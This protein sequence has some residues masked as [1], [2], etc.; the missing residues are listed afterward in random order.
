[1]Q[2]PAADTPVPLWKLQSGGTCMAYMGGNSS[3]KMEQEAGRMW[4]LHYGAHPVI[5]I[6]MC[7]TLLMQKMSFALPETWVRS[8]YELQTCVFYVWLFVFVCAMCSLCL[9]WVIIPFNVVWSLSEGNFRPDL[10][11]K[12]CWLPAK[13]FL[14]NLLSFEA[15][16]VLPPHTAH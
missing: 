12:I 3:Q 6:D 11:Q 8:E 5:D 10:K 1:M 16:R 7:N 2:T 9:H 15:R 14:L 13:L 4:T